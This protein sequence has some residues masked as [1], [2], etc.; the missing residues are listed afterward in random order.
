MTPRAMPVGRIGHLVDR[1]GVGQHVGQHGVAALVVG[2]P[3]LLV[4]GE[5]HRLAALAHEH[6]VAGRLEVLHVD[7]ASAPGARRAGP[8]R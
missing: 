3:L 8:P 6:A 5:R 7:R 1:V 2:H 4:V